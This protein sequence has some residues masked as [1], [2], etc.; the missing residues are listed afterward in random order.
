MS[1]SG[2]NAMAAGDGVREGDANDPC[3]LLCLWAI[4]VATCRAA[5]RS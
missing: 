1:V 4:L 5:C 2:E 3:S